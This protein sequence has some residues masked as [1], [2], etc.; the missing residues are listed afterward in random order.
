MRI[1]IVIPAY[2]EQYHLGLCLEAIKHQTVKPY[3]V[4]VV[5]NNSTDMSVEIAKSYRFVKLIH[6][7]KQGIVFAR[8][9]GF[10]AAKGSVIA[11]IDADT[12]LPNDWV[13]HLQK[14]FANKNIDAV[15]GSVFYYDSPFKKFNHQ[16]DLFI[17]SKI[18][19]YLNESVGYL[20][21]SNMALRRQAWL[22]VRSKTCRN[23]SLH[24]DLDLAI[25][26]TNAGYKLI[27][28]EDLCTGVSIRAI[29]TNF[30]SFFK[31][32]WMNPHTYGSHQAPQKRI[33]YP[34]V[35]ILLLNYLPIRVGLRFIDPQTQ[36][37]HLLNNRTSA[38]AIFKQSSAH[39]VTK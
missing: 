23:N 38:N 2:N 29:K 22:N 19:N 12:I 31:Y 16:A 5:D 7:T 15:T 18:A 37:I 3:Q 17:R 34:F 32:L 30:I 14:I 33:F 39:K 9:A 20:Y 1:S 21:G 6:A 25:H 27:F 26:L 35:F 28:D 8:N 13:E 36:K 4:I 24:E 10:D 11:R